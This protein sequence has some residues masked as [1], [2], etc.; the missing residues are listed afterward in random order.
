VR[1]SVFALVIAVFAVLAAC[2]GPPPVS[3]GGGGGSDGG[4][5]NDPSP[6]G[7][8]GGGLPTPTCGQGGCS[9]CVGCA[10]R[11]GLCFDPGWGFTLGVG[12]CVAPPAAGTLQAMVGA[13]AF[14]ATEVAAAVDGAAM[15]ISA[16]TAGQ[17]IAF[18]VPA[19]VGDYDCT[20][21]A[22]ILSFAYYDA[23]AEYRN[24]P[25]VDTRPACTVRVTNVGNVGER[26]EGSF[27]VT[28]ALNAPTPTTLEITAG[29][30]SVQRVAYP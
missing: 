17:T 21:P 24:R 22:T 12:E 15:E 28:L 2:A 11:D 7:S 23:T 25:A 10:Q 16:R 30:F 26:I 19:A 27:A 13:N 14:V 1:R 5:S 29:M 20:A 4:G 18:V 8:C 6:E 9:C 3:G